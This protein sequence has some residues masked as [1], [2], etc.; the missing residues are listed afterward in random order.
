MFKNKKFEEI[1]SQFPTKITY[2]IKEGERTR[3]LNKVAC[4]S[5]ALVELELKTVMNLRNE[6][7]YSDDELKAII[8]KAL[9]EAKEWKG[10]DFIRFE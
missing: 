2:K 9:D 4:Y 5:N 8:Q 6:T 3:E 10:N 1:K 7:N